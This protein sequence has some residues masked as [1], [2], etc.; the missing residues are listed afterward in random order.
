[1]KT[2]IL[3]IALMTM[4]AYAVRAEYQ[5]G[6]V[7]QPNSMTM[8]SFKIEFVPAYVCEVWQQSAYVIRDVV[9]TN[10]EMCFV[11]NAVTNIYVEGAVTNTFYTDAMVE[12]QVV[13]TNNVTAYSFE[14]QPVTIGT[15]DTIAL[16]QMTG[17]QVG[18]HQT[19]TVKE[20]FDRLMKFGM[21]IKHV[22]VQGGGL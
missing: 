7:P 2:R 21:T 1:M 4:L 8:L 20:L 5:I 10:N 3:L 17:E 14:P 18:W 22:E 19:N 9:T 12:R 13:S 11:K 15:A 16:S 6:G